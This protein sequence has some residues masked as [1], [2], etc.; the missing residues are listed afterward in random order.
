MVAFYCKKKIRNG[1][2]TNVYYITDVYMNIVILYIK[3]QDINSHGFLCSF[4]KQFVG[5]GYVYSCKNYV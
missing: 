2:A 5:F 4:S 3:Q 1:V